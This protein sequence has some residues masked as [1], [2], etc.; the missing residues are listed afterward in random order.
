VT[1]VA[2]LGVSL[3]A[4]WSTAFKLDVLVQ[5]PGVIRVESHNI[6]VQHADGG[7]I[8]KLLVSEGQTV[9]KGQL[10]A[11]VDNTYVS[12]EFAKNTAALDA[13]RLREQRLNA[14]IDQTPFAPA[15]SADAEQAKAALSEKAFYDARQKTL[16]DAASISLV[17]ADQRSAQSAELRTRIG[18]LEKEVAL[19]RQ[20]VDMIEPLVRKGAAAEGV[21]LQKRADLQSAESSLNEARS[22][23]PRIVAEEHEYRLKVGQT[24]TD[25]VSDAQKQLSQ[26]RDELAQSSAKANASDNRQKHARIESPADGVIQRVDNPHAGAVVKPGGELFE[27]APTDVPL[28]AQIKIRPEDRDK[29]WQGMP[30]RVHVNAFGNSYTDTLNGRVAIVS[31]DALGDDKSG[32]FYEVT[33]EVPKSNLKKPIYPGMAVESYLLAG[34]RS[35]AQYACRSDT[36]YACRS[37]TAAPTHSQGRFPAANTGR[38]G[39]LNAVL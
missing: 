30:A 28:V 12:E 33:V 4:L 25:F 18:D 15:L 22:K 14:E 34:H 17:Q 16:Q 32:R 19:I 35:L 11:V 10:L 24:R 29:I 36:A 26:V 39:R 21:L 27:I 2:L 13:L 20:Q 3:F 7:Q 31:A 37:D 5:G 9:H 38:S 8:E 6:V 23:V 1:G